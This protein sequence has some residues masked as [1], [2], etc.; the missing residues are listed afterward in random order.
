MTFED[1]IFE[2]MNGHFVEEDK[3]FVRGYNQALEDL[4]N[5]CVEKD[6]CYVSIQQIRDSVKELKK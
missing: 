1:M 2:E 4:L 6:N 3:I 5:K